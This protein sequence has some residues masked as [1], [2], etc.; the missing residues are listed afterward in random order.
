MLVPPTSFKTYMYHLFPLSSFCISL[1]ESTNKMPPKHRP[2]ATEQQFRCFSIASRP[3]GHQKPPCS[4]KF[5]MSK[6][7][8]WMIWLWK[9]GRRLSPTRSHH[10][11]ASCLPSPW[12]KRVEWSVFYHPSKMFGED[13]PRNWV[14]VWSMNVKGKIAQVSTAAAWLV[15]GVD[16]SQFK[17][18]PHIVSEKEVASIYRELK[19]YRHP[20]TTKTF[21]S[22]RSSNKDPT[23]GYSRNRMPMTQVFVKSCLYPPPPC[24]VPALSMPEH[25]LRKT[26]E[27]HT[28]SEF[29][30]KGYCM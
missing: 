18:I 4:L 3:H 9:G 2:F 8:I 14:S 6:S 17:A 16:G 24:K 15:W 26:C 1:H 20:G 12:Q 21:W 23:S 7:Q 5:R 28:A 22:E 29:L 10:R 11:I 25:Y 27:A 19:R 30:I 13:R